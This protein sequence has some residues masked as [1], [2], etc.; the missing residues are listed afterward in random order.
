MKSLS[1]LIFTALLTGLLTLSMRVEGANSD[2]TVEFSGFARLVGG[3]LNADEGAFNSYT[4]SF[5]LKEESLL[6]LR[7]DWTVSDAFHIVGQAV[8]RANDEK[9][10]DIQWLYADYRPSNN[11]SFKLG[12]QR[13]PIFQFSEV[14]DVGF[15]YPWITLPLEI[16]NPFIFSEYDGLLASYEFSQ[17]KFSGSFDAYYG[18]YDDEI[19]FG[20]RK[21]DAKV[22]D[23]M[24]VVGQVYYK[25]FNFRASHHRGRTKVFIDELAQFQNV[26]RALGFEDS[27]ATLD[28][29]NEVRYFQFSAGWE[30]LDYFVK[31]ELSRFDSA[32]YFAPTTNSFYVTAGYNFY[33]FTVHATIAQSDTDY[34]DAPNEIPVGFDPQLDFLAQQ[35]ALALQSNPLSDMQ[36]FTLGLRYDIRSNLALKADI[37]LIQ[38]QE[39]PDDDSINTRPFTLEENAELLQLA[40][41]W[42]F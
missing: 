32:A 35:Y 16:Y 38:G 39:Q 21:V 29:N 40:V 30:N 31:V 7:A 20:R 6:G 25:Q 11:L 10:S 36:T 17:R 24:G 9:G 13:I 27:A 8:V 4:D 19:V 37:T 12:R 34:G 18:V 33:P 1:K 42:V 41:E 23:L 28:V 2:K 22:D 3:Y 14:I 26:L 15:A 5:T